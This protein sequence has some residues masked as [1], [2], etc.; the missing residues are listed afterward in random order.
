MGAT[1]KRWVTR[2]GSSEHGKKKGLPYKWVKRIQLIAKV[3]VWPSKKAIEPLGFTE[4]L[5]G[6]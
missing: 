1:K 4:P 2:T 3:S 6:P 5:C